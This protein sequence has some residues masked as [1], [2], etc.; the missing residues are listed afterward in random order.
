[1]QMSPSDTIIRDQE[2][3]AG[4]DDQAQAT[5]WF[6]SDV[7]FGLVY[8]FVNPGETLLDLGIGSGLSSILFHRAGLQVYGLDASEEVL[9]VCQAKNFAVDLKLHDLREFPLPYES[10]SIKHIISV[11]VLNSFRDLDPLFGE[12]ARIMKPQGIFAFTVEDQ[13]PGQGESYPINRV[14]VD[15]APDDENAVRLFRHSSEYING[16]LDKHNYRLLKKLE[17]LA[18]KYPAENKDIYFTAYIARKTS[19]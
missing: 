18:F 15:K 11:A 10:N 9:K 6:G 14:E 5:N 17:F 2:S 3:A 4:Y 8:E 7:V 19:E 12:S 1:M 13:K 16:L